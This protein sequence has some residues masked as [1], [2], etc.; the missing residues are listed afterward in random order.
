MTLPDC[1]LPHPITLP[2]ALQ[3]T[4]R[5]GEVALVGAGPGDPGLL[6]V[7]AW[8]LLLQADALVYDRLV[9]QALL[10]LLPT[11]CRHYYVGKA[12]GRHSLPQEEI[13]ELLLRLARHG[14]RVARL[15]GGDPF[16]FGRGGE[17]IDFLLTHGVDCQLVP[18]VTA[19]SGCTA[20]AGIPLTHRGVA[21]SCQFITGHVQGNGTLALPWHTMTDPGCTLV[22]YMGLGSLEE[23]SRELI[24]AGRPADTPAMLVANGTR[25]DQRMLRGTLRNLGDMARSHRL[26]TPTLTVV[27]HVVD[28]MADRDTEYPGRLR[29]NLRPLPNLQE[30]LC[31]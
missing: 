9:S 8:S 21:H 4:F 23:I 28:L 17:E 1:V 3:R 5:P 14:M 12:S 13:N 10:D 6:T 26:G 31:G 18:G 30:Q 20:Y 2:P 27:G 7:A 15:K 19:A 22:F 24:A 11:S 29:A 25:H 16:I